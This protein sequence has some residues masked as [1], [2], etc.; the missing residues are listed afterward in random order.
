MDAGRRWLLG[1]LAGLPVLA[2]PAWARDFPDKPIRLVIPFPGGFTDTLARMVGEKMSEQLGQP[3][4]VEQRPGGSGQIGAADVLRS[5]ADGHTLF[6]MHIGTHAVNPHLFRKLSYDADKDFVLISE[7]ARV[8][9]LLVVSPSLPVRT[10]ADLVALARSRS[11]PLFFASP[12]N[13]SSGHLA[14][15]LLKAQSGASQ[16]SHVAYKGASET[17]A[18]LSTGRVHLMFDTPGARCAARQGRQG[19]RAR[20]GEPHPPSADAGD[21]D[22]DRVGLSRLGDRPLVRPGRE[23]RH[24]R[25]GGAAP[26]H[27]RSGRGPAGQRSADRHGRAA[28]RQFAGAVRG[29]GAR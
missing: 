20:G 8:P 26:A 18:D 9:N 25:A 10:V 11:E 3:V 4:I 16:F 17:V 27:H 21:P 23:D 12:G 2:M 22:D 7:L 6:M 15:E 14:G 28:R 29:R 19:A 24:P 5:P 1:G 13:G